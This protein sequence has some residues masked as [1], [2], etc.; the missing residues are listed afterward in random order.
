MFSIS[1]K[2]EFPDFDKEY[3]EIQCPICDLYTWVQLG[4]IRRQDFVICR[5][6]H[7]NIHFEDHMGK[8]YRIIKKIEDSFSSWE[9]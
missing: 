4:Y 3:I 8:Y 1:L 7:T 5:G 9:F 2:I 6:C